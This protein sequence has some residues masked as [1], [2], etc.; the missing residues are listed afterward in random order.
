VQ[1]LDKPLQ[2]PSQKTAFIIII[3]DPATMR[4]PY[5]PDPPLTSSPDEETIVNAIRAR[6]GSRGLIAIDRTV[7]HAP[8]I[9][10]GFN[11]FMGAI[12]TKN[13]LPADIREIAFCRVAALHSCKYEWNEHSPLAKQAGVS[14]DALEAIK[15]AGSGGL[16]EKQEAVVAYADALTKNVQVPDKIFNAA[17]KFFSDSEMLEL[18]ASI[19]GFNAVTRIVIGLDVG[20]MNGK[21]L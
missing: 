4:L 16:G 2:V 19:A 12:R 1:T 21:S 15:G 11:A 18:T 10:A 5:I 14:N 9:A 13:S 7:L 8:Q 20:E 3:L 6:R 17:K